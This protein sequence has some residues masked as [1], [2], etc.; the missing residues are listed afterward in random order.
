MATLALY[1]GPQAAAGLKDLPLPWEKRAFRPEDEDIVLRALRDNRVGGLGDENSPA[2]VFERV[3]AEYQDAT[4]GLVVANGTVSL[5]L[6]LRAGGVR[7]GD[8]VL[9]PAITFIASAS[10]VVS[11]GAVPVFVDV[12]PHTA[13]I[14]AAAM[15][16]AITPRTRAVMVVHY[17]GYMADMDAILPVAEK[18][19]VLVIMSA[20]RYRITRGCIWPTRSDGR[21]VR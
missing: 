3:F 13:Q 9:V 17:G 2:A 21:P 1:G 5:E 18:H 11:V 16:T 14:S 4:Y 7:P 10:A 20:W 15:E 19:D 12:D 6:A 8:E